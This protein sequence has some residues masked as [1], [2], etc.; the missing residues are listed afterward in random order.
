[1]AEHPVQPGMIAVEGVR[2]ER[3]VLQA[4]QLRAVLEVIHPRLD[5]VPVTH[6]DCGAAKNS[7]PLAMSAGSPSRRMAMP[8]T[9]SRWPPGP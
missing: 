3:D 9:R 5:G 6:D 8:A 7:N 4:D 1:V 2:A